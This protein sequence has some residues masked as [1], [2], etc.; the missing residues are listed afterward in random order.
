MLYPLR[1]IL[2][3]PVES[4]G[5][6]P[7]IAVPRFRLAA[8]HRMARVADI[9]TMTAMAMAIEPAVEPAR[10]KPLIR[11]VDVSASV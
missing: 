5:E 2:G 3:G 10:A 1:L 6:C 9:M 11:L 8:S 4:A 7:G